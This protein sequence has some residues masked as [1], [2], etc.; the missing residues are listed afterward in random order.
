[1]ARGG[2]ERHEAWKVRQAARQLANE[3]QEEQLKDIEVC[4]DSAA[5]TAASVEKPWVPTLT[6]EEEKE[7]RKFEKKLREIAKLEELLAQGMQLDRLQKDKISL[8]ADLES[9][10]VMKKV[11]GGYARR[12]C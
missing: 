9:K 2:P 12:N 1:V 8:R 4:S 11:F 7:A 3:K 5:S 6:Y 10:L